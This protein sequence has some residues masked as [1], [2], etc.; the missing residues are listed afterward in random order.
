MTDPKAPVFCI[1]CSFNRMAISKVWD[2]NGSWCSIQKFL[3]REKD[4]QGHPS[5]LPSE[6]RA[7]IR[8]T[9][10]PGKPRYACPDPDDDPNNRIAF[11]DMVFIHLRYLCI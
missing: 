1:P 4:S 11:T 5:Q 8:L 7:I 10:V 2:D 3:S 6:T 9:V